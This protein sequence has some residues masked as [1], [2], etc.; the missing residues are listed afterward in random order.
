MEEIE[1][2]GRGGEGRHREGG[3]DAPD[4]C[5]PQWTLCVAFV[6]EP[7]RSAFTTFDSTPPQ[8]TRPTSH[9]AKISRDDSPST[10]STG[11]GMWIGVWWGGAWHPAL[12]WVLG[13]FSLYC[14]RGSVYSGLSRS[15]STCRLY[16]HD[17][18]T[19]TSILQQANTKHK[20]VSLSTA[21]LHFLLVTRTIFTFQNQ[22]GGVILRIS[23]SWGS[24]GGNLLWLCY[25]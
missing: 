9:T 20:F 22:E 1:G 17:L 3:R 15:H 19:S 16:H 25:I 8:K 7:Q 2:R 24:Q 5:Q 12:V 11:W 14:C 21:Q 13:S 23:I 6:T 4:A 18:T 10:D